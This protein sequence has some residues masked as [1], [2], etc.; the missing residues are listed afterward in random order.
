MELPNTFKEFLSLIGSPVFIGI[1]LSFVLVR[2]TWFVNL[3]SKLKFWLVGA[4]SLL[5]PI[6][7]KAALLYLPAGFVDFIEFWWPTV[8]IGMGVWTTSQVWNKL[9]GEHGAISKAATIRQINAPTKQQS[10]D[11]ITNKG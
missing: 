3:S 10:E 8:V 9:F 4:V 2:W 1:I 6:A 5:L 7:S 11:L